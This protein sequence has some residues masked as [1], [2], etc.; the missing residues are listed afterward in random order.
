MIAA[1]FLSASLAIGGSDPIDVAVERYQKVE[2]YEVT[3]RSSGADRSDIIRF[4]YKR[5]GFVRMDFVRPHEGAVLIYSPL[6]MDVRLWPFGEKFFSLT[7]SPENGLVQS[8]TG[9]RVD[10]SDIGALL[11]HVK[12]LQRNGETAVVGE[13]RVGGTRALRVLVSGRGEFVV[14]NVHRYD[15]WLDAV[16]SLPLKVVSRD[17]K[18]DII[19][20]VLM[21][22]LRINVRLPDNLFDP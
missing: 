20:T 1:L 9:Q 8:P 6:T 12:T 18:G 14:G 15:L 11:R 22:D 16:T 13:E 2:S 3:L 21:D 7:L 10:Q 19:E 17:V 4:S 5:P